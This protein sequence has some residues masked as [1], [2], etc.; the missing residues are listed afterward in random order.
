M[1]N[2]Q[3][4]KPESAV[5]CERAGDRSQ[6]GGHRPNLT[7]RLVFELFENSCKVFH[8][9]R[10]SFLEGMKMPETFCVRLYEKPGASQTGGLADSAGHLGD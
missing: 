8:S 4:L 10:P 1:A 9:I 5:I 7:A 2:V 6:T 3:D